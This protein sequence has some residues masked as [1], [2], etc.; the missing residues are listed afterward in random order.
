MNRL[1]YV[2]IASV[3]LSSDWQINNAVHV[4][5][6]RRRLLWWELV[7]WWLTMVCAK[8]TLPKLS[9]LLLSHIFSHSWQKTPHKSDL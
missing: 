6:G 8:D 9:A 7:P 2:F 5:R 4:P 1:L 3:V